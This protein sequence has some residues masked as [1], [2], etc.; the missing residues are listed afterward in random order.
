MNIHPKKNQ[1]RGKRL[2][3]VNPFL[4]IPVAPKTSS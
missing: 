2:P 3:F 4:R 1:E